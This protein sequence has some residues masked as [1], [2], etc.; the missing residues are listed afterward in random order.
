M[1]AL[2]TLV[3]EPLPQLYLLLA[4]YAGVAVLHLVVPA[5]GV[6]PGHARNVDDSPVRY[7]LNGSRSAAVVA[8]AAWMWVRGGLVPPSYVYRHLGGMVTAG[9][10][11]GVAVSIFFF[12]LGA[13]PFKY[14]S[15][16]KAARERPSSAVGGALYDLWCGVE[17][18]PR[19]AGSVW[20][21]K[22]WLYTAGASAL[23][24]VVASAA[25]AQAEDRGG[26][27]TPAMTAYCA[28]MGWFVVDYLVNE[29]AHL[30]TY[31]MVAENVGAKLA[32]GCLCFYPFFYP[33]G[34]LPLVARGPE[35]EPPAAALLAAGALFAAGWAVSRGANMQKFYFRSDPRRRRVLFGLVRQRSVGP[36][37]VSGFW[38]VA[39]H[40]NYLGEILMAVALAVPGG[41]SGPLAWVPW[42]YPAYYVALLVPR[43]RDDDRELRDK[44]GDEVF[45]EYAALVPYRIVPGVY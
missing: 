42:L 30:Y 32:F 33:V 9:A 28:M 34:V 15:A 40:V 43:Q 5:G 18:S 36:L 39:R 2:E 19:A 26:S 6:V 22:L 29:H 24:A 44:Y 41:L 21:V 23:A 11:L 4:L 10:I 17:L 14:V 38:G 20:D 8:A 12:V 25:A 37:L 27:L 35:H 31:D 3:R 16:P 13:P 1:S 45:E 7:R